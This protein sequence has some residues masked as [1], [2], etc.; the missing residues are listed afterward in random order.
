VT[1]QKWAT[2]DAW[3]R[4]VVSGEVRANQ[5][6]RMACERHL[7]DLDNHRGLVFDERAADKAIGLFPFLK[8]RKGRWAGLPLTLEPCQL[9]IVGSVFGWK[10]ADGTRRFRVAFNEVPR[11]FGKST[12]A[13][14]VANFLAFFDGEPGAEV[15]CTATKKDQARIVWEESKWQLSNAPPQLKSALDIRAHNVSNPTTSSK[16]DYIGADQDSTDGL[17]P[18]GV[19]CDEIH[20]WKSEEFLGKLET[21]T[22]A[23]TQPLRFMITTAGTQTSTLYL[24]EHNYAVSVLTG[25]YEDDSWFVF[26]SC[27]DDPERWQDEDQWIIANPN[28][29]V[30]V[31]LDTLRDEYKRAAVSPTKQSM[32]KR[33]YLGLITSS[34]DSWLI[35]ETWD[36]QAESVGVE[37]GAPCFV[38]A[39]LAS[40][41]DIA[42]L[43]FWFPDEDGDG[44]ELVARLYM[45]RANIEKRVTEDGQPYDIWAEQGYITL[46]DGATID[47]D[48]IEED[49]KAMAS[50]YQVRTL[51]IDPWQSVQFRAHL[52]RDGFTVVKI[53]QSHVRLDAAVNEA[54]RLLSIGRVRCA[55]PVM[56][57]MALNAVVAADNKGNRK[58]DKQR[59]PEKIDGM[60][61]W[62]NALSE[63]M[64]SAEVEYDWVVS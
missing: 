36:G 45:P 61:A 38:G 64:A 23:R 22:G 62:L 51:G 21:A 63:A 35:P 49:F 39:D 4:G 28:V 52:E 29:G 54:E 10:R 26:I 19:I 12:L 18:H 7:R 27:A 42:A 9:F 24:S 56:R 15:Y 34:A 53:P 59:S 17:N 41:R 43:A 2:A 20:A 57:W 58:L 55:N 60:V 30:T 3:A 14:G 6:I 47:Y 8:Q 32:F 48:A 33:M 16:L 46:T 31:S 44:G 50:Q 5:K 25:A 1:V 13:A 37:D 11:K 40:I